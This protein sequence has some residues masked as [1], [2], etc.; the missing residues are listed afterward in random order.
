MLQVE[1]SNE[2]IKI[3]LKGEKKPIKVEFEGEVIPQ[4]TVGDIYGGY[5]NNEMKTRNDLENEMKTLD[6]ISM[7]LPSLRAIL[8]D[9]GR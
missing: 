8:K 7:R 2:L 6:E 9:I 1:G 4:I 5:W 3:D